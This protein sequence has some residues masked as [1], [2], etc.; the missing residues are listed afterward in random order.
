MLTLWAAALERDV[1][2][3]TCE[4]TVCTGALLAIDAEQSQVHVQD[5]A[6]P[7][8]TYPCATVRTSDLL[9]AELGGDWRLPSPLPSAPAWLDDED[10]PYSAPPPPTVAVTLTVT[11]GWTRAM[12]ASVHACTTS[13]E[14]GGRALRR[15]FRRSLHAKGRNKARM[16]RS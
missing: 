3:H 7:M 13:Q 6:T 12:R 4:R 14:H 11:P 16:L 15:R 5:L 9:Y 8:G 2:L 1:T 10:A